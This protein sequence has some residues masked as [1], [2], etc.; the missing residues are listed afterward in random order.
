MQIAEILKRTGS[1]PGHLKCRGLTAVLKERYYFDYVY[2]GGA[3]APRADLKC[4]KTG[5]VRG[6]LVDN[7]VQLWI[8]KY[9]KSKIETR[10]HNAVKVT[11]KNWN[12]MHSFS[13]AFIELMRRMKLKP[14]GTQVVVRSKA[15]DLATLID[16]VF[17]NEDNKI[18]LVELKCGFNGYVD[19]SNGNMKGPFSC[20]KNS[21]KFQHQLQLCFTKLMFHET[22]PEFKQVDAMIVRMTESGAYVHKIEKKIEDIVRRI[23]LLNKKV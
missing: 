9:T 19:K 5:F 7:E 15:C 16:G 22:F 13:R 2:K 11:K 4:K 20:L 12:D 3:L 1:S 17:L 18:V 21:P 14:V 6:S 10:P 23:I 8:K